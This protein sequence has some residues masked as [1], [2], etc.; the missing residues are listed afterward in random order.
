MVATYGF[1]LE[2]VR[3]QRE[4]VTMLLAN[5]FTSLQGSERRDA[6]GGALGSTR[7]RQT[8][9]A[10]A[11]KRL[12]DKTFSSYKTWVAMMPSVRG[13][14]YERLADMR[15]GAET[16]DGR[17]ELVKNIVLWWCIWGEA[18]NLRFMPELISWLYYK[19]AQ[20][21]PQLPNPS[22][23]V[24]VVTPLYRL[25]DAEFKKVD[26][27]GMQAEHTHIKNYDDIN[28]FFW[29]K[30]CLDYQPYQSDQLCAYLKDKHKKTYM[31]S[32]LSSPR[33]PRNFW[34]VYKPDGFGI[35]GAQE[36]R[37]MLHSLKANARPLTFYLVLFHI[38]VIVAHDIPVRSPLV[39]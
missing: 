16:E 4:N 32:T 39:L 26:K 20:G 28:E 14:E 21:T 8:E 37:G 30:R 29:S 23:L 3:N 11:V 17:R 24:Q 35:P 27:A 22:Y 25:M 1:Q 34:F 36:K 6:D 12:Y 13:A 7:R 38:L 18:A 2:S 33:A 15:L 19:L 9:P 10:D 31:V 5:L